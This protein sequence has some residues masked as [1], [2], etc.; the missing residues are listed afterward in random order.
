[1]ANDEQLTRFAGKWAAMAITEPDTGSDSANI[2]TTAVLDGDH[3]VL[4]GSKIYITWGEHDVAD[5]I[6]HLVLARLPDAPPGILV[7][8]RFSSPPGAERDLL[9][10]PPANS[11]QQDQVNNPQGENG[12]GSILQIH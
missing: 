9:G 2:R 6:V 12:V 3:Y 8:P 5:N 11:S 1:M 7:F 4:N 10:L